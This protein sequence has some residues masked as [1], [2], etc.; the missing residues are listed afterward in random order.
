MYFPKWLFGTY[1]IQIEEGVVYWSRYGCKKNDSYWNKSKTVRVALFRTVINQK[2]LIYS[3]KRWKEDFLLLFF[4]NK[5]GNLKSESRHHKSRI[6]LCKKSW[7]RD[8]CC[9]FT[10]WFYISIGKNQNAN[11]R[12]SFFSWCC[13]A[14]RKANST[15]QKEPSRALF[16][17]LSYDWSNEIGQENEDHFIILLFHKD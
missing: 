15:K 13:L 3:D 17:S 10:F 7:Y 11:L 5:C 2:C 8:C 12:L 4:S 9:T 6:F 14:L 16:H 1:S